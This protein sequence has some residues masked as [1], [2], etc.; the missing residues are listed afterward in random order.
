MEQIGLEQ[1][2]FSSL[3]RINPSRNVTSESQAPNPIQRGFLITTRAYS[4]LHWVH[5]LTVNPMQAAAY[6]I[7]SPPKQTEL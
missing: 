6:G 2:R 3:P 5:E 7:I 4:N 1:R